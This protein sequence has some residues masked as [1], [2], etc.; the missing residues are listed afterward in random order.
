[1]SNKIIGDYCESDTECRDHN[2][3]LSL[4]MCQTGHLNINHSGV[5]AP[6]VFLALIV[7]IMGIMIAYRSTKQ[8]K[9]TRNRS[10]LNEPLI[11]ER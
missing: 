7:I 3:N 2:C 5:T 1:M 9:P 11:E 10:D 8:R 4:K 6:I